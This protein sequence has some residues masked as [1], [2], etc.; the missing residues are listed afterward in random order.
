MHVKRTIGFLADTL[1]NKLTLTSKQSYFEN[2]ECNFL[3]CWLNLMLSEGLIVLILQFDFR[4]IELVVSTH[5]NG[6]PPII[7]DFCI[8]TIRPTVPSYIFEQLFLTLNSFHISV[9]KCMKYKMDFY[10]ELLMFL[11][12]VNTTGLYGLVWVYPLLRGTLRHTLTG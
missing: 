4:V 11:W 12:M 2:L 8:D 7:D 1:I 9:S 3:R 10:P 5:V 6:D